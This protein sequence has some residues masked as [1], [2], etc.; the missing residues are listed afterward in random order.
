[1]TESTDDAISTALH[2]SLSHLDKWKAY[3]RQ[4]FIEYSSAFSTI[5]TSK[6]ITKLRTLGLN[7][8]LCNWIQDFL[9]GRPQVVRVD[10]AICHADP[11]HG[12]PSWEHA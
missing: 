11:Q 2:T 9:T 8:S 6:P 10:N 5:V 3:V 12:C 4:L 1:M 7:T